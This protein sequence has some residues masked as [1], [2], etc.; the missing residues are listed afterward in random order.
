MSH[1]FYSQTP[2]Q[3]YPPQPYPQQHSQAHPPQAATPA[4]YFP[5]HTR[6]ASEF[7]A[8]PQPYAQ[9]PYP[10]QPYTPYGQQPPPPQQTPF[11]PFTNPPAATHPPPAS[12]Y[13]TQ[14]AAAQQSQ[15]SPSRF[16]HQHSHS[17]PATYPSTAGFSPFTSSNQHAQPAQSPYG[18]PPPAAVPQDY[19]QS[20]G[21]RAL[22]PPARSATVGSYPTGVYHWLP[23][24]IDVL[25]FT[26][27]VAQPSE[28]G[29]R[30]SAASSLNRHSAFVPPVFGSRARSAS[31]LPPSAIGDIARAPTTVS[32]KS[33]DSGLV[34]GR[35]LPYPGMS[36]TGSLP[37][38]RER[39]SV[40]EGGPKKDF[41]YPGRELPASSSP[42]K[43]GYIPYKRS[44]TSAFSAYPGASAISSAP[45]SPP[46]PTYA[47]QPS[48]NPRTVPFDPFG[49]S[50]LSS[51]PPKVPPPAFAPRNDSPTRPFPPLTAAAPAAPPIPPP[52]LPAAPSWPQEK[53]PDLPLNLPISIST[54]SGSGSKFGTGQRAAP[55]FGATYE[56]SPSPTLPAYSPKGASPRTTKVPL[57]D[58]NDWEAKRQEWGRERDRAE[59]AIARAREVGRSFLKEQGVAET[60]SEAATIAEEYLARRARESLA[61][62]GGSPER[63][64][65]ISN[66]Y[67]AAPPTS[68]YSSA[69]S[70]TA[71]FAKSPPTRRF[72]S[73]ER[74][75]NDKWAPSSP[76]RKDRWGEPQG[77]Y[78]N[79]RNRQSPTRRTDSP[80]RN[81]YGSPERRT[82]PLNNP[83]APKS[84]SQRAFPSDGDYV[85]HRERDSF[86]QNGS[87]PTRHQAYA[88]E[89]TRS[90]SRGDE[91]DEYPEEYDDRPALQ[92]MSRRE[93]DEVDYERRSPE[94][95]PPRT[96]HQA[97]RAQPRPEPRSTPREPP[98]S[99]SRDH[100]SSPERPSPPSQSRPQPQP[101]SRPQPRPETR[102]QP[103]PQAQSPRP[104]Q[105]QSP[106][107]SPRAT[108]PQP[109]VAPRQSMAMRFAAQALADEGKPWPNDVPQLPRGPGQPKPDM[110]RQPA[111]APPPSEPPSETDLEDEYE[112]E[113]EQEWREPTPVP[114]RRQPAPASPR[115]EPHPQPRREPPAVSSPRRDPPPAQPPRREYIATPPR[116]EQTAMLPRSE[117]ARARPPPQQPVYQEDRYEQYE[118]DDEPPQQEWRQP[119]EKPKPVQ[120]AP[121]REPL[122]ENTQVVAQRDNFQA[123]FARPRPPARKETSR[124]AALR[125]PVPPPRPAPAP[126][127]APAPR[128][129]SPA[130]T[131]VPTI[132]FG[133][134]QEYEPEPEPE[135][136]PAPGVPTFSFDMA[137]EPAGPVVNVSEPYEPEPT[138]PRIQVDEV[139]SISVIEDSAPRV[140]SQHEERGES[141]VRR[142]GGLRC[143]G[144]DGAIAGRIVSAMGVRWHPHCFK[145]AD[146][147]TLLEHVSSYEHEGK[148]Y[149]H[150]DY[151]DRFAPRCYHCKTAIVDERFIALDDPALGGQRYYHELH[152]FCA[153]CGDPFLDPNASSAAPPAARGQIFGEGDRDDDVGFTVFNGHAYCESCHV[154][155]RMPRCGSSSKSG[156]AGPP[157]VGCGRPIREEAIEALGRKWHWKCFTCDSCKKPFEDPSFFQRDDAAFCDPCYRILLKNEF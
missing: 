17:V 30:A 112:Y 147:G 44:E 52:S 152:F 92:G 26:F 76:S 143:A 145:C 119:E 79:Y 106:V 104:P 25:T 28:F 22:P 49:A 133:D 99:P 70:T 101:Q 144:C 77:D 134:E 153:E 118:Y 74:R 81:G 57:P 37:S 4:G 40:Y 142:G 53:K 129:P 3:Q 48:V 131:Q 41:T 69:P 148:A 126:A 139:P 113:Q 130:Q 42:T 34:N 100:H 89:P 125:R 9:S 122:R 50:S 64:G 24:V 91:Y 102:P 115:R 83:P 140:M 11:S 1:G 39:A 36:M 8:T 32:A 135:P 103:Q 150:L 121:K 61:R 132:T 157:G 51:S 87:S 29:Q 146:C 14:P 62:A 127:P 116:R 128:T 94:R 55:P 19:A 71:S 105:G 2:Y 23:C 16:S 78:I 38:V 111:H 117:P 75:P 137:D 155:L 149:C 107:T 85:E 65:Q 63:P 120:Q 88:S 58:D 93:R 18:A 66:A 114:A 108:P 59:D 54:P 95:A 124:E 154:R 97:P 33:L 56:R 43:T 72:Q 84:R 68:S 46:K 110:R 136:E 7:G 12:G 10:A 138:G 47:A 6:S 73:P 21:Q 109:A 86:R 98:V 141:P 5:T 90:P 96:N 151:H 35:P 156:R 80:E 20:L 67:S 45:S 82:S 123:G 13:Q 15:A 60:K 31:P 27:N